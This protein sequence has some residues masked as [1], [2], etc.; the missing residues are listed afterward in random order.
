MNLKIFL[1][2]DNRT[3]FTLSWIFEKNNIDESAPAVKKKNRPG[4]EKIARGLFL[5]L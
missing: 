5:T 4:P 1:Q 2:P 3:A